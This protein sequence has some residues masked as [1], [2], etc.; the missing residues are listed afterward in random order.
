MAQ[1]E[2][3]QYEAACVISGAW[4]GTSREKLYDDLGW[5]SLHHRRNCRRLCLFYEIYNTDFPKYLS[6][7]IDTYRP[8]KSENQVLANIPCR[9]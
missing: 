2:S 8:K 3:V 5:E 7:I 6:K 9:T 4:K 1:L